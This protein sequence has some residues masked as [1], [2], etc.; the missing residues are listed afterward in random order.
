VET[1]LITTA[2]WKYLACVKG[3]KIKRPSPPKNVFV[4]N[5]ETHKYYN[6]MYMF[7]ACEEQMNSIIKIKY[8]AVII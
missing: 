8:V 3:E 4:K 2:K 6:Y 5:N 7:I 1:F